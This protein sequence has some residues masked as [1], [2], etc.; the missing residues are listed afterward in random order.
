[1]RKL[2]VVSGRE[3]IRALERAGFY[4]ARQEG[5]HNTLVHLQRRRRTTVTV[6]GNEDLPVGTLRT[7]LRQAGLTVDEF[8]DLLH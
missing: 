4:L 3:T 2:P 8:V 5:S 6:H 1:M 7:I